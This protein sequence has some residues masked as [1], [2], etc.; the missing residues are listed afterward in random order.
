[1][2]AAS[3][4]RRFGAVT[5]AARLRAS[6]PARHH[7][8]LPRAGAVPRA[9][10]L[11]LELSWACPLLDL[12]DLGLEAAD[13]L[14]RNGRRGPLRVISSRASFNS[15]R[16]STETCSDS[17]LTGLPVEGS[18]PAGGCV[19]LLL[20]SM[21]PALLSLARCATRPCAV[22]TRARREERRSPLADH[23][24]LSSAAGSASRR[25]VTWP[26]APGTRSRPR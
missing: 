26:A 21:M 20:R 14:V 3:V 8:P 22:L 12:L 9:F 25:S 23:H 4:T 6:R 11:V 13:G 2:A 16:T 15:S 10:R 18:W 17:C 1:M 19:A 24:R 7:I 5:A